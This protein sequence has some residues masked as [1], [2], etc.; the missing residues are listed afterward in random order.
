MSRQ[1]YAYD[2]YTHQYPG[3]SPPYN[4]AA[5]TSSLP[6]SLRVGHVSHAPYIPSRQTAPTYYQNRNNYRSGS[7]VA[8]DHEVPQPRAPMRATF[9]CQSPTDRME[10]PYRM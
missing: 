4:P 2:P 6:S 9:N 7:A 5:A 8:D 1:Y 3:A 10:A